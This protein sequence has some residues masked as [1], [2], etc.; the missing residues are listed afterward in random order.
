MKK[1]GGK[2]KNLTEKKE[3]Q[4]NQHKIEIHP[5]KNDWED[6]DKATNIK[7]FMDI[8]YFHEYVSYTHEWFIIS[9]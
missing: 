6:V 1:V 3:K 8:S 7:Y 9:S 4:D 2:N 5:N